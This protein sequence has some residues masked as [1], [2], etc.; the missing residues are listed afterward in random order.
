M[1]IDWF[2]VVAQAINFLILV[3][4]LKRYLYKPIL[5]AIDAREQRIAA[6]LADADARKAAAQTERE[7]FRRKNDE[8]DRQAATLRNQVADE[9]AAEHKRLFDEARKDAENLR[10]RQMERLDGEFRLLNAEVARRTRDEA[11]SIARHTLADLAGV[12]IEGRMAEVF[13]RRLREMDAAEKGLL[14]AGLPPSPA[15]VVRSAFELSSQQR[16]LVEAAIREA[17]ALA[18]PHITFEVVPGLMGGIELLVQGRKVAWS[19]ADYLSSLDKS[20][21]DLVK[22]PRRAE[23]DRT[24]S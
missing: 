1:L 19:I 12:D 4:L 2:T 3:W 6:Q 13:V 23:P 18:A 22:P 15:V 11:F 7:E 14:T 8:F 9:A 10:T 17:L 5:D 24:A 21:G 16:E 20:V